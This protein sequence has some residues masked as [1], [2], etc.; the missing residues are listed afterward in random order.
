LDSDFIRVADTS[1][2][3]AGKTKKVSI[4]DLAVL[5]VNIEGKFYAVHCL[6]THYGGDLSEGTLNGKILT[7]PVHGAR[8]DVTDGKVVSPPTEPL[9]RPEI[10]NLTVYPLRVENQGIF[11]KI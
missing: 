2:I 5:I 4:P 6:C 3:A 7:C 1:E 8:F 9:D 10:E 11:I